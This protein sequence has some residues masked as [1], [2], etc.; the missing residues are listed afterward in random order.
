MN[1]VYISLAVSA[2]G[3]FTGFII[4]QCQAWM[5]NQLRIYSIE[6]LERSNKFIVIEE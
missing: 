1:D 6:Q 3:L 2:A 4:S 5:T